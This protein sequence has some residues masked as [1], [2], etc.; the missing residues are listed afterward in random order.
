MFPERFLTKTAV[1]PDT[2]G[3]SWLL[4]LE[5]DMKTVED[6]LVTL[7]ASDTHVYSVRRNVYVLLRWDC[8]FAELESVFGAGV[9]G[10]IVR[11]QCFNTLKDFLLR[12]KG[13]KEEEWSTMLCRESLHDLLNGLPEM[14][15][16]CNLPLMLQCIFLLLLILVLM[17]LSPKAKRSHRLDDIFHDECCDNC[18]DE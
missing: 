15:I 16:D 10:K 4:C 8:T 6:M 9:P 1:T 7:P 13:T 14:K 18:N 2:H 3:T 5:C 11:E 17:A 12:A